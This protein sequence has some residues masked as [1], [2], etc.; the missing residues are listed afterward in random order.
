MSRPSAASDLDPDRLVDAFV[1]DLPQPNR[2]WIAYSG[3]ID[4][5]VLLH[6]LA[7]V[8]DR[9]PATLTAVHV[10]HGLQ[11]GSAS[12]AAHCRA[13]CAALGVPLVVHTVDAHPR[14]GQSPEAAARDARYDAIA[15]G[16]GVDDMLLTAHH[17]DDQA[18]TVLLQ[19]LR[20]A[21]VDGL[22]AMPSCRHW[23]HGWL[24]R[25]LLAVPRAQ[26]VAW[27]HARQLAW[28]DDPSNDAAVADRNFLRHEILPR[29]HARW[30]AAS[31]SLAR[32]AQWCAEAAQIVEARAAT[33][34]ASAAVAEGT[35][36][37][38]AV[39]C[40][41]PDARATGLLRHWLDVRAAPPMPAARLHQALDQ[42]C[43]ARDDAQPLVAWAGFALR[44][45]RGEVWL[46]DTATVAVPSGRRVWTGA[47]MDLGPGL[48]RIVS[49]EAPGGIDADRWRNGVIEIGYR[50]SGLRCALRGRQGTRDFKQLAQEHGIPPWLR[51][52]VP[53]VYVDGELAAVAG[54]C[55]CEPFSAGS[56]HGFWPVWLHDE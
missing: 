3:G 39:L 26:L 9:L 20:G 32:S 40:G 54:C 47:D 29:L 6:L 12:W 34:L 45:Y 16:M 35:R 5:T 23:R 33:D 55:V 22:S 50:R 46:V 51:D 37:S 2:Y 31:R 4:S 44:R 8:R 24:A 18:E 41:L 10:D 28:I 56:A 21:G 30:P 53:L 27:A 11:P 43:H 17:E 38:T 14:R 7:S 36:L 48:G 52:R 49:R 15:A 1:R 42:L 19:L 13:R 25:P